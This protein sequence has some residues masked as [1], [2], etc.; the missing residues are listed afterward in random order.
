[1]NTRPVRFILGTR[2]S[3]N[4]KVTVTVTACDK[5]EHLICYYG[6]FNSYLKNVNSV[7]LKYYITQTRGY[8]V[9]G[10]FASKV[11]FIL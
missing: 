9:K 11:N 3:V 2:S 5:C 10:N 1:M 6:S 8:I 7:A 4:Y